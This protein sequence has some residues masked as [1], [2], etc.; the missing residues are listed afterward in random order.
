ME[1]NKGVGWVQGFLVWPQRWKD[2]LDLPQA[3]NNR[4]GCG[5]VESL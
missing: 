1:G 2:S 5:N 3:V 4:V